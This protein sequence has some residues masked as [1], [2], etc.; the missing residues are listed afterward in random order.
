MLNIGMMEFI[1]LLLVAFVIVGP[2]DLPKVARFIA[3]AVKY[4]KNVFKDVTAALNLEEEIKPLK[5]V[6]ETVTEVTDTVKEMT[7]SVQDMKKKAENA[8]NPK[9]ILAPIEKEIKSVEK[10][11]KK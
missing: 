5:E 1:I 7:S 10:I 2:K 9:N 11:I 8:V 6:S 3:R 4:I